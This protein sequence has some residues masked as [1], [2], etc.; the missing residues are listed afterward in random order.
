MIDRFDLGAVGETIVACP[1]CGQGP[2]VIR[3]PFFWPVGSPEPKDD[4]WVYVYPSQCR[5]FVVDVHE[6]DAGARGGG[7]MIQTYTHGP[8]IARWRPAHWELPA[9]VAWE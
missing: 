2:A 1:V 7:V 4:D 8:A 6:R 3:Q 9:G 5:R